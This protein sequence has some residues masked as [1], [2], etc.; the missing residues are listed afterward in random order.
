MLE[1]V[2]ALDFYT[3]KPWSLLFQLLINYIEWANGSAD[4]IAD[5]TGLCRAEIPCFE[6]GP[7]SDTFLREPLTFY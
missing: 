6:T 2:L 3:H 7:L 4:Y 1:F 5:V